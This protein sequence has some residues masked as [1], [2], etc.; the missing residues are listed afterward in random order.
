MTKKK[1]NKRVYIENIE[2]T[3]K[4]F[5]L[6]AIGQVRK[7]LGYENV[8]VFS[9]FF[10]TPSGFPDTD[11]TIRFYKKDPEE[12]IELELEELNKRK[13]TRFW[14]VSTIIKLNPAGFN[15][16]FNEATTFE[17]KFAKMCILRHL[18][19][20][21]YAKVLRYINRNIYRENPSLD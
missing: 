5:T 11:Y 2:E 8:V 17:L 12:D 7:H 20:K 1:Q 16:I 14:E 18:G 9:R 6:N 21:N 15:M 4:D 13:R 3:R 10:I 19:D